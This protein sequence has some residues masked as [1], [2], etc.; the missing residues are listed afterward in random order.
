MNARLEKVIETL[1]DLS[2]EQQDAIASIIMD[3]LEDENR[4]NQT[5]ASS[6]DVLAKL[7]AQARE[8]ERNGLVEELDIDLL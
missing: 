8:D 5:F 4:W 3:E 1:H 6:Q 2:D 7:A